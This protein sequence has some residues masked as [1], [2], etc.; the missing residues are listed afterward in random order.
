MTRDS[1]EA[2]FGKITE[3][4]LAKMRATFGKPH[5]PQVQNSVAS[6]DAIRQ[7]AWG[8]GDDNRLWH[9][10]EYARKSRY[11]HIIAPPFFLY[12]V[13]APQGMEGLPGVHAFHCECAWEWSQIIHVDDRLTCVDIPTDLVEKHGKMGGR[14]FLQLGK[15]VYKNQRDEI[16]AVNKRATMRIERDTAKER[17]K[18][19]NITKYRYTKE[20]LLKIDEMYQK[21][22]VRGANPR[23]WE[24][25]AVGDELTPVVKGPLAFT[26]M[27]EFM[28][29]IGGGQGAHRIRWKYMK[30]HP[31]WGVRDP[32]T[33][34]LEPIADVHY[35][36]AK[37]DAIGVPIAY[38]LGMQRFSWA[39]H[40]IT[41]WMGDDGFLKKLNARCI[42]FNV[43]GDTQF[44]KGKVA[45][46]YQDG[47]EYLVDIEIRTENQRGENTMPGL[48]TVS[49]PSKSMW[50]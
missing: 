23:Y 26:D 50:I 27:V 22:E 1:T 2:T 39:G 5:Y 17:G 49:L 35:E 48:A 37:S 42:L 40:L 32:E 4:G 16:V 31:M 12:A 34:T 21:E 3:E 18:Y 10:L 33:G 8:I 15:T 44:L 41:N 28:V 14:Q 43:F 13:A 36:S 29:G 45:R 11:G 9:D 46:K 30:R 19:K 38:D 6:Q 24:D 47:G 7:F 25:V 20:E